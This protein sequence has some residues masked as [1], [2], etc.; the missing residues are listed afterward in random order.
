MTYMQCRITMEVREKK[1]DG[2]KEQ[3]AKKKKKKKKKKGKFDM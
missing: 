1:G 3:D 2:R